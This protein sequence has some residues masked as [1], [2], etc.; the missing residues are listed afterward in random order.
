MPVASEPAVGSVITSDASPP[1]A[2]TRQQ[3][4]LLFFATEINQRLDSV[5]I[6][7]PNNSGR[8]ASLADFAH[9][10]E[11]GGVG[12]V[13]AAVGFG[14]EHRVHAERVNCLNVFPGKFRAAIILGRRAARFG[15][16]ITRARFR[17]TRVLPHSMRASDQGDRKRSSVAELR[18]AFFDERV[19]SF[20]RI[21]GLVGLRRFFGFDFKPLFQ[22]HGESLMHRLARQTKMLQDFV[23]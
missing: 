22:R 14:N 2:M 21:C 8:R 19:D 15:R 9:A 6:R 13:R 12:Q 7:C 23:R 3:S 11:I 1:S 10:G 4:V 17:V 5:K 18:F 20:A 16:G